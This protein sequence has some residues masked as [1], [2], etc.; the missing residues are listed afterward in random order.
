MCGGETLCRWKGSCIL[1]F[2]GTTTF[3]AP[4]DDIWNTNIVSKTD[5]CQRQF[6]FVDNACYHYNPRIVNTWAAQH[7]Y[8]TSLDAQLANIEDFKQLYY[9]T[10]WLA[11]CKL[12]FSFHQPF[13]IKVG[14]MWCGFFLGKIAHTAPGETEF[15][16]G[17][18]TSID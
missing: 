14:P 6:S 4:S 9:L 12:I 13:I 17:L 2:L 16:F 8:C 7:D 5:P 18:F 3:H 11:K 1:V 15:V 10:T